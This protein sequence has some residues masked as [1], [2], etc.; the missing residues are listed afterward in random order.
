MNRRRFLGSLAWG[1]AWSVSTMP[2]WAA[3]GARRSLLVL[4][5]LRGGNDGLN[6]IVPVDDGR[7]HDLRPR[8]ALKPDAVVRLASGPALHPSLAALVPLWQAGE[9]AIVQGVG[10][11]HP[12][13]SHFRSIEIWDTAADSHQ[14]VQTGWLTRAVQLDKRFASYGADG[15]VIGAADLGPLGGGAR[16]IALNDPARLS[17]AARLASGDTAPARGALA[18][19]V[20]VEA[21]L[22]RAA[23]S[24]VP[25][26]RFATAFPR[27]LA[28]QAVRHAAG[29]AATGQVPIIRLALPG[30]DTHQA[31]QG[32]HANLLRIVADSIVALRSALSEHGLWNDA[33]VLT[34]SEFGRRPKE[35][36]TNGTDHGTASALLAIGPRVRGGLHGEAPNLARLDDSGNLGHTVDFRRVYAEVLESLWQLPSERVLQ[37]RFA[38]VGFL[39]A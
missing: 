7:Y 19:I 28:G 2:A 14:V 3:T 24:I 34:Y 12:N 13:L 21:D 4:V 6:T 25:D 5:E 39:R 17:A 36:Q 37:R 23:A 11:P 30:F 18:H 16:A 15:V 22:A 38:P 29:V 9:L 10:Y 35:N 26:A 20:R 1:T 32:A 31:Q 33:L 27:G 8:L